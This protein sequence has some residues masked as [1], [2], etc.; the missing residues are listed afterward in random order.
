MGLRCPTTRH[1][2]YIFVDSLIARG[3]WTNRM[4]SLQLVLYSLLKITMESYDKGG[5]FIVVY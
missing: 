2:W 4:Q 3:Q 1:L 5:S